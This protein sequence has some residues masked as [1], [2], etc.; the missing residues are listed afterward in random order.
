MDKQVV[1]H[2]R[3]MVERAWNRDSDVCVDSVS[4]QCLCDVCEMLTSDGYNDLECEG[5]IQILLK[6]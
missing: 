1:T 5:D 3:V 2:E 4:V 6:G